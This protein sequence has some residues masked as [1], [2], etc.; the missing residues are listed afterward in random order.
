MEGCSCEP[1]ARTWRGIWEHLGAWGA[2][3]AGDPLG[4]KCEGKGASEEESGGT[5]RNQGRGKMEWVFGGG[6]EEILSFVQEIM[7]QGKGSTVRW[8]DL[9][10]HQ[11]RHEEG[12]GVQ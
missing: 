4:Q 6:H 5:E 9:R 3:T 7:R 2:G 10:G 8:G 1:V 11:G 12:G